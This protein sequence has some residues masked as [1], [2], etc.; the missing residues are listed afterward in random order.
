MKSEPVYVTFSPTGTN[1]LAVMGHTRD[2]I[3]QFYVS[4]EILNRGPKPLYNCRLQLL[5]STSVDINRSSGV[6]VQSIVHQED[7]RARL[8]EFTVGDI[9]APG[10]TAVS[11]EHVL[12]ILLRLSISFPPS[13]RGTEAAASQL[14]SGKSPRSF[15]IDYRVT[16]DGFAGRSGVLILKVGT[17]EAFSGYAHPIYAVRDKRLLE[18]V[19][20]PA[21]QL[22]VR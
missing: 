11:H 19:P 12:S 4:I 1:E 10:D 8:T 6:T 13:P 5:C 16:A 7:S 21:R 14:V 22:S 20:P 9:Y 3:G 2:E 15:E 18:Y 17:P